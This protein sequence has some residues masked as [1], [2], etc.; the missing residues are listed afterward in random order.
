MI[1][2]NNQSLKNHSTS[3][4]PEQQTT[5]YNTITLSLLF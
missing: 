5:D 3:T 4:R 1:N 2:S